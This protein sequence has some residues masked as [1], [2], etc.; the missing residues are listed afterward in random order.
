[1]VFLFDIDGTLVR[2]A[3]PHHREALE[4]AV[5]HVTGLRVTTEGIPVQGMLDGEIV[6]QMMLAAGARPRQIRAA[7]P[8]IFQKAPELYQRS[9]P[10]LRRKVCPGVRSF[11][12]RVS[13]RRIPMGLVTGNL[14]QIAWRKLVAAG[15]ESY[16]RFGAFADM[17][18]TRIELAKIARRVAIG[19]FEANRVTPFVLIGDHP[20]DIAAAKANR[21]FSVAVGTGVVPLEELKVH[22]PDL[23]VADLRNLTLEFIEQIGRTRG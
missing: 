13:R 20:N 23:L 18:R 9:C 2:R 3:G 22:Q 17:G 5:F 21:F 6:R 4:K 15:I 16:F 8:A 12:Y 11:L 19:R 10:D 7:L 14:R 1:M